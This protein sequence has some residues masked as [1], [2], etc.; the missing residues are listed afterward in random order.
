MS[1]T[2]SEFGPECAIFLPYSI[3]GRSLSGMMRFV[4]NICAV[5]A[6]TTLSVVSAQAD[7]VLVEFPAETAALV[8]ATSDF[9]QSVQAEGE[10]ERPRKTP[11]IVVP[12]LASKVSFEADETVEPMK[13]NGPLRHLTGYRINWYPTDRLLGSVDFMGT[14]DGNRN[15]VCGYLIWDLGDPSTPVLETVTANYIDLGD[16]VGAM[17][18]EVHETLLEANCAYGAIDANYAVFE[19]ES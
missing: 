2:P 10:S 1:Q 4:Q 7:D 8:A 16:L 12:G 5:V 15:L 19:P 11:V 6:L 9:F 13:L 18:A 17:P 3:R 14:W